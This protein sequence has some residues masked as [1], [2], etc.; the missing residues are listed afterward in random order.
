M[1]LRQ[2]VVPVN[3]VPPTGWSQIVLTANN[4]CAISN[5]GDVYCIGDGNGELGQ[6][7]TTTYQQLMKVTMP[8]AGRITKFTQTL[9]STSSYKRSIILCN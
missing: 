2:L 6:G 8:G 4:A 5:V 9:D 3:G 1:R 7:N